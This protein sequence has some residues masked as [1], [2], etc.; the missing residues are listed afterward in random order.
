MA[1]LVVSRKQYVPFP[2]GDLISAPIDAK[3]IAE[4]Y[5]RICSL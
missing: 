3:V 4:W 1:D 5:S 2:G